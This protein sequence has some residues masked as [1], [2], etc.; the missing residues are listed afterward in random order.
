[1]GKVASPKSLSFDH[2]TTEA[3]SRWQQGEQKV[4]RVIGV[5]DDFCGSIFAASEVSI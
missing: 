1:M 4:T 3:F 2:Q 5:F